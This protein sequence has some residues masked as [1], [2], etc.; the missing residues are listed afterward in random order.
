MTRPAFRSLLLAS[1]VSLAATARATPIDDFKLTGEGHTI[2]YSLPATSSPVPDQ[3]H[4]IE[5]SLPTVTIV[6]GVSVLAYGEYFNVSAFPYVNLI[7][8]RLPSISQSGN[9]YLSGADFFRFTYI[10]AVNPYPYL[11]DDVFGTFIAGT[12]TLH[13]LTAQLFPQSPPAS[14]ILTITPETS[15]GVTPEPS[16]LTL[17]G[18]GSLGLIGVVRRRNI[19]RT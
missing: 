16:T 13:S 8:S 17:L 12:Y 18:T 15:T 2:T 11:Q 14:Y 9:L 10:P 4:L 6:D 5:F 7:L 1:I 3:L 19:G